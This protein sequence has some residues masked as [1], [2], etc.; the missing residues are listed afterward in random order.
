MDVTV[1]PAEDVGGHTV[2]T[3][4][5][6]QQVLS[7]GL[8]EAPQAALAAAHSVAGQ[9]TEQAPPAGMRHC[10]ETPGNNVDDETH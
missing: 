2:T 1:A 3:H 4:A 8:E 10:C 6:E 5:V 7:S 9:A